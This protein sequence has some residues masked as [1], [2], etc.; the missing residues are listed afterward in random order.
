MADL[1]RIVADPEVCSGKP[2]IRGTRV[3]VRNVLSILQAGGSRDEVLRSYPRLTDEDVNAA[4]A[5]AIELV[6]EVRLLTLA[7]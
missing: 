1:S 2:V 7:A 4:L 3:M 6:D 5:Y